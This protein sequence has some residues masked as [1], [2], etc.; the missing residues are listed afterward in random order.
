MFYNLNYVKLINCST[1]S[2]KSICYPFK[3]T[4]TLKLL[5]LRD[6]NDN[7]YVW[8]HHI[9]KITTSRNRYNNRRK[10]NCFVAGVEQIYLIIFF[11][12]LGQW[13]HV[14][15]VK[16]TVCPTKLS[17]TTEISISYDYENNK[18]YSFYFVV[19]KY[20]SI[21]KVGNPSGLSEQTRVE[22]I[23]DCSVLEPVCLRRAVQGHQESFRPFSKHQI[24]L[25]FVPPSVG[26]FRVKHWAW[27]N[28]VV[29]W[30]QEK[31]YCIQLFKHYYVGGRSVKRWFFF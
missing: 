29:F 23:K 26:M 31:Y 30:R 11:A 16:I 1:T 5:W 21:W 25:S 22:D 7:L 6:E 27:D 15:H 4:V 8:L 2:K 14:H 24:K 20:K 12:K 19:R 17:C 28:T 18:Q 9:N 13:N 10:L 3:N